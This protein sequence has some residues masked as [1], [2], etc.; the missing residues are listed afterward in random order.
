MNKPSPQAQLRYLIP[1]GEKPIYIAS[2]GGAEA[3]LNINASF[4]DKVVDIADARQLKLPASLDR[5]GFALHRHS[6]RVT[7][8]YSLAA[9]ARLI[10]NATR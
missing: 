6:S 9:C 7:D 5:E 2:Q 4:E 3:Q 1:S 10:F 8:F